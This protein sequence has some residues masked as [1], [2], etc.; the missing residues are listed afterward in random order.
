MNIIEKYGIFPVHQEA[1]SKLFRFGMNINHKENNTQL[2]NDIGK[3][4]KFIN[5]ITNIGN[6]FIPFTYF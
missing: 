2:Y 1:G 6:I 4:D 5:N 3:I